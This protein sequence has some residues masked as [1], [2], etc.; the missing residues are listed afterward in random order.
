MNKGEQKD[1]LPGGPNDDKS[2]LGPFH[3]LHVAG[4]GPKKT[5]SCEKRK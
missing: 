5:V 1:N 2:C 4:V 3:A